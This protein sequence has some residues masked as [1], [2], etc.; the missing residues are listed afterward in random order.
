MI[1]VVVRDVTDSVRHSVDVLPGG[2][3]GHVRRYSRSRTFT[4]NVKIHRRV[5]KQ[6][7]GEVLMTCG[8][9]GGKANWATTEA[10]FSTLLLPS[11]ARRRFDTWQMWAT[12]I[13]LGIIQLRPC[14][15][16]CD[17]FI[18]NRVQLPPSLYT[19]LQNASRAEHYV[20]L[21]LLKP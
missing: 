17:A 4:S 7:H 13:K 5:L 16:S 18:L 21:K 3:V 15:V 12:C 2:F 20:L 1:D 11:A 10:T 6:K 14:L 8:W 9:E 19:R